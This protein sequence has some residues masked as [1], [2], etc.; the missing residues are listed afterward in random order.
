MG[1]ARYLCY[2]FGTCLLYKLRRKARS[3]RF[4]L[5]NCCS[6]QNA[7][8]LC[9][10][11]FNNLHLCYADFKRLLLLRESHLHQRRLTPPQLSSRRS[12]QHLVLRQSSNV[13]LG[14]SMRFGIHTMLQVPLQPELL[15]LS[16]L[17]GRLR[18]VQQQG[19]NGSQKPAQ[20]LLQRQ[21]EVLHLLAAVVLS[22]VVDI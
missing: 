18:R 6:F 20:L 3:C 21:A 1:Q 12:R 8:H 4:L 15:W 11:C 22:L 9:C 17:S 13:V 14:L 5:E 10:M 2:V 16:I 19:S 7:K